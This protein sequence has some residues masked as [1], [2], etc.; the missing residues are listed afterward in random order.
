VIDQN[1]TGQNIL[2]PSLT[3]DIRI[4]EAHANYIKPNADEWG[5]DAE[6]VASDV[7][8]RAVKS[9]K[10]LNK[11]FSKISVPK[12]LVLA[13]MGD[14]KESHMADIDIANFL[15]GEVGVGKTHF[16]VAQLKYQIEQSLIG[17]VHDWSY[18]KWVRCDYIDVMRLLTK[19]KGTFGSGKNE[20]GKTEEQ[21]VNYY[22]KLDWLVLDDLGMERKTDWS[23]S[24]FN[25][26]INYRYDEMLSTVITSNYSMKEIAGGLGERFTSRLK[27][28]CRV[29]HLAGSDKRELA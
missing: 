12:R 26:I 1:T 13:H 29:K 16:A 7:E 22:C 23:E 2:K 5:W 28:M 10:A 9:T 18:C 11:M 4:R 27:A 24:I 21:I 17:N 25:L 19:I 20:D 6:R 3:W 8:N 14:F 15:T